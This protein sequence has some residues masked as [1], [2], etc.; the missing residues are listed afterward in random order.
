MS[1]ELSNKETAVLYKDAYNQSVN[2]LDRVG[3]GVSPPRVK[4]FDGFLPKGISKASMPVILEEMEKM[5]AFVQYVQALS[6]DA[7]NQLRTAEEILKNLKADIRK[8]KLGNKDAKDDATVTDADFVLANAEYL[9]KLY[10]YEKI[11]ARE[12]MARR[13]VKFLSRLITASE[14]DSSTSRMTNAVNNNS[15]KPRRWK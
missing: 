15:T 13:D 11:T 2:D 10:S 7:K 1:E 5:E 12:E 9:R 6:I 3:L 14:V 4:D 8:K